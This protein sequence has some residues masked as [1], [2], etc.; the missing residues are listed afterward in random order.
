MFFFVK[1]T[2]QFYRLKSVFLPMC[3][4]TVISGDIPRG[5]GTVENDA[6]I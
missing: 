2:L 4:L 6:L 1:K 5:V 3:W